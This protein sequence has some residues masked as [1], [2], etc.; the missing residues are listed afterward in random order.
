M[1]LQH[2]YLLRPPALLLPGIEA[3]LLDAMAVITSSAEWHGCE[4][5]QVVYDNEHSFSAQSVADRIIRAHGPIVIVPKAATAACLELVK[6]L[7]NR[8]VI[9]TRPVTD[10]T[11]LWEMLEEARVAYEAGDPQIPRSVAV[12]ILLLNKLE[13]ERMWGGNSKGFK[14]VGLLPTGRGMLT[15]CVCVVPNVISQLFNKGLLIQKTSQG[16]KKYA[17]NRKFQAA[18]Y[19]ILTTQSLSG[20]P[21]LE[22]H[23][24]SRRANNLGS[25]F[26]HHSGSR[27]SDSTIGATSTIIIQLR[28][29]EP[30]YLR[31]GDAPG[32][33]TER[34]VIGHLHS[35]SPLIEPSK[36]LDAVR[37]C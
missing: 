26:E 37:A 33:E 24:G 18:I 36:L 2:L 5:H 34:A 4:F 30:I 6:R 15:N 10:S 7:G 20:L 12:A 1:A 9:A 3:W 23:F 22:P 35:K 31:G 8:T 17:L 25:I 13:K 32:G 19:Q 28:I 29:F 14:C 21:D 16:K 11:C 27:T